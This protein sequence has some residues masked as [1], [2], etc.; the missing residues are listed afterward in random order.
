[1]TAPWTRASRAGII[2]LALLGACAKAPQVRLAETP[3]FPPPREAAPPSRD[4]PGSLPQVAIV[5]DDMGTSL[6]EARAFGML[7]LDL[8]FAVLPGRPA[9]PEVSRALAGMGRLVLV[10]VPMEPDRPEAMQGEEFLKVSHS[11][12]EIREVTDRA[13]A[14]VPDARGAN[15]HMG[16][17]FTR[18]RESMT[19]FADTLRDRG[20]FFLDSRTTADSVA[21]EVARS[22]GI[23]A[24]RRHVFLDHDPG[25]QA[26]RDRLSELAAAA[27]TLGCAVAIGHPLPDTLEALRQLGSDPSPPFRVVPL[28]ALVE[29][30]CAESPWPP[31]ADFRS[32]PSGTMIRQR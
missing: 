25:P 26:V 14:R 9:A 16:S 10:H 20:L 3:P 2:L 31:Q 5:I 18:S 24:M 13:L 28:S 21:Q 6:T 1:M 27:R 23:A 32:N 22:R 8:S 19:P 29:M 12:G 7:P 17:R 4:L 15:S 30:P 11:P